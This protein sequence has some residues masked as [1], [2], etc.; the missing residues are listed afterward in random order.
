MGRALTIGLALLVFGLST[1]AQV[2]VAPPEGKIAIHPS[3]NTTKCLDV[4]G[5]VFANGTPVQIY[6]CNETEAQMWVFTEAQTGYLIQLANTGF[7]LDSVI[8]LPNG[9]PMKLWDCY[10]YLPQQQWG[11]TD[12]NLIKLFNLQYAPDGVCLDLTEGRLD[13][14]NVVQTWECSPNNPNQVWTTS[15]HRSSLPGPPSNITV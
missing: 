11:A 9:H 13:N 1:Q 10:F 15:L 7:C 6:D 12:N 2:F 4:R 5:A 14:A 3:G 8:A